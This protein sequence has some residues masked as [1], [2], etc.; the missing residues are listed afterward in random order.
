MLELQAPQRPKG[1]EKVRLVRGECS[2]VTTGPLRTIQESSEMA[3]DGLELNEGW[4]GAALL[5]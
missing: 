2:Q 4:A 5:Y 1:T 3:R